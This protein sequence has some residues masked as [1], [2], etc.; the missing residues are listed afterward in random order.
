MKKFPDPIDLS[1]ITDFYDELP[2]WSAPFGLKLLEKVNYRKSITAL[3]IGFGAGFPLVELAERLGN[4]SR[5]YGI[6][7]W[8]DASAKVNRKSGYFGINS[9]TLI[10][11]VAESIPLEKDS[12]DLIVSNNGINNVSD[13]NKVFSECARV[14][15]DSGQF[16][17]T[18]NL[19]KS[20]FEFYHVLE[21]VLLENG[22]E[23]EVRAMH[24]HIYEKRK[25]LEEM[26]FLLRQ[27]GFIIS[28]LEHSQ[29]NYRFADGTAM[30]DHHFIRL[31]FMGAWMNLLP[32]GRAENIFSDVELLLNRQAEISG[33]LNL[34]IPFV[35]INSFNHKV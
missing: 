1:S 33:G 13:I 15:K 27:N 35:V 23:K 20:M 26:T 21:K 22:M 2:F 34:S 7:P 19:D 17:M 25:P 32:A 5:V 8:K 10:E 30:L 18:M 28:D 9:I 14:L 24:S 3:D 11:G 29:F 6:D 12:V 4:S 16:V 31:A